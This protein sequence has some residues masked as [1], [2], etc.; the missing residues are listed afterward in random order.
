MHQWRPRR[1]VC[2]YDRHPYGVS[3]TE[4][5]AARDGS[6]R[7][8]DENTQKKQE[9]PLVDRDSGRVGTESHGVSDDEVEI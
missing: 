7:V 4:S 3:L 9:G 8:R 1:W 2:C 5:L 6:R